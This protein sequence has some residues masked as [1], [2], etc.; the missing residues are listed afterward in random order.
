MTKQGWGLGS[1]Q[2]PSLDVEGRCARRAGSV[3]AF[4]VGPD[5][6]IRR[7]GSDTVGQCGFGDSR[8]VGKRQKL[9]PGILE[10][11]PIRLMAEEEIVN[12]PEGLLLGRTE[13]D[14]GSKN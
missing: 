2:E 12:R 11:G 6:I 8:R 9:L 7:R 5:F 10:L 3:G 14:A 4:G 1:D 13:R